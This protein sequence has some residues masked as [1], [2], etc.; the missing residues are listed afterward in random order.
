[1]LDLIV[2]NSVMLLAL[3]RI[4][5]LRG[6][7]LRKLYHYEALR[8]SVQLVLQHYHTFKVDLVNT[9]T[10]MSERPYEITRVSSAKPVSSS[11]Q[12]CRKT[13]RL[14]DLVELNQK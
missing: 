3:R 4:L 5:K 14:E 10:S 2:L 13:S 7:L 11:N 6:L 9:E 8:D 1:M 12:V